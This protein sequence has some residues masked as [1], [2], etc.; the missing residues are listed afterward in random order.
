MQT[1]ISLRFANT[2]AECPLKRY[3]MCLYLFG[4]GT[5]WVSWSVPVIVGD[6]DQ[7]PDQTFFD[8]KLSSFSE[9]LSSL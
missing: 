3:G 5:F 2:L 9:L 7:K 6:L 8:I 1:D 4:T